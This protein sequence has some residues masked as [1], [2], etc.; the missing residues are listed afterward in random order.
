MRIKRPLVIDNGTDTLKSGYAGEPRPQSVLPTV[1]G[2]SRGTSI[3]PDV[4]HYVREYYFGEETEALRGV[5]RLM[6]PIESGL[7]TDWDTMEKIWHYV[8]HAELQIN[9]SEHPILFTEVPLNP[10]HNREKMAE[11]LFETFNV[12]AMAVI[13]TAVLSLRSLGKV[14]GL[15]VDLGGGG[16]K[17]VP[18][19]ENSVITHAIARMDISGRAITEYLCRLLRQRGYNLPAG[20]RKILRDIKERFCYI[21]LDP[22]VE[23]SLTRR[24]AVMEKTYTLPD[25]EC[26]S[27]G[28]ERFLAPEVLFNP[29]YIGHE[30]NPLH[31]CIY[32]SIQKC[33]NKMQQEFYQNIVLTGGSSL[34]PGL[35]ERLHKELTQMLPEATKVRIIASPER[36]LFAW[37]GGSIFASQRFFS[38]FLVWRTDYQEHGSIVARQGILSKLFDYP[39]GRDLISINFTKG[40][41]CPFCGNLEMLVGKEKKTDKYFVFCPACKNKS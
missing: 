5:L 34:F 18:I 7:V 22:Q 10:P 11:I 19:Y 31:E 28:L 3:M 2:Y 12:P 35:K 1:L 16:V 21:V 25:G 6:Y 38:K 26:I 29:V 41:I 39:W 36:N 27:L 13:S 8:F 24:V 33:E 37:L 9:P 30:E 4:E 14:T 40:E 32:K 17:I 23:L 15:V 20:E